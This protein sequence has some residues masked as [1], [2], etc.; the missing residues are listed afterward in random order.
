LEEILQG[1]AATPPNLCFV[2]HKIN[3]DGDPIHDENGL[4][5]FHNTF[6]TNREENYQKQISTTF[7]AWKMSFEMSTYILN[8]HRHRHTHN[9]SERRRPRFPSVGHC[10]M[11]LVDTLQNLVE[12][13]HGIIW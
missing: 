6:G 8:E 4:E 1:Y 5:H 10:D 13:N 12:S 2:Y 9:V 3:E 11:W 7:G